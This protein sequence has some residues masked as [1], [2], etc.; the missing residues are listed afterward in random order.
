MDPGPW[1]AAV[2]ADDL[3]SLRRRAAA[4]AALLR[5]VPEDARSLPAGRRR[6][7]LVAG[8]ASAG[9]LAVLLGAF[10]GGATL[11]GV[12]V[13]RAAQRPRVAF[14]FSGQS[15]VRRRMGAD[16]YACCGAFSDVM[17]RCS[18]AA[19]AAHGVELTALLYG[20]EDTALLDDARFAQP[21]LVAL[22]CALVTAWAGWGV[23]P[24][25]VAGHS[26]G[27]YAAACA[28]GALRLDETIALVIERGA[29][30]QERAASDGE[31]AAVLADHETIASH[32]A[33]DGAVELAG[34][35]APGVAVLAGP[36]TAL[37]RT[38]ERLE[39]AGIRTMPLRTTH[40]FHSAAIDPLLDA[41]EE[42]AARFPPRCPAVAFA[43]ALEGGLLPAGRPLDARYW[44]RHA[45]EPVRFLDAILALEAAGVAAFLE[46]GPHA[47]LARLGARCLPESD[48]P[49]LPSLQHGVADRD[50]LLAA[51]SAL[52]RSGV[53]VDLAALAAHVDCR[54]L[55]GRGDLIT[56]ASVAARP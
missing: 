18:A 23:R 48:A 2:A 16:L 36:R 45:R 9:E 50:A 20:G 25:A 38:S 26:L 41:L 12:T 13:A 40:A 11:P 56:D 54:L 3:A 30:T 17:D 7:R 51:A 37:R 31:M 10:A 4:G 19:A 46:I 15:D 43:S 47:T 39:T 35:N 24:A 14:L 22:Q 55:D 27:E 53:A 6:V 5:G 32:P 8:G 44:R 29:L 34:V 1:L 28:A 52:W 42:A 49:F 33:V 21:A